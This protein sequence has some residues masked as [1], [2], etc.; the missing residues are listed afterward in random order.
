MEYQETHGVATNA[1][2]LFSFVVG[3]GSPT[4]GQFDQITWG[5]KPH[6]LQIEI[7]EGNG[8]VVMGKVK[9]QSVPYALFAAKTGSVDDADADPKNE[10]QTLSLSGRTISLSDGG[11]VTLPADADDD[12]S[13]EIQTL[14][15]SGGT[16]S[17]SKG[18]S[19][20]LPTSNDDDPSNEIQTL[21]I[22]NDTIS[23]TN[24]GKVKLPTQTLTAGTGIDIT[25]GVVSATNTS[26]LWNASQLQGVSMSS[27]KPN[28][29]DVLTY[30]GTN[31]VPGTASGGSS[32][33]KKD[34]ND[35]Y[36]DNYNVGIGTSS[37]I[38]RLHITDSIYG[39]G[40]GT[41]MTQNY[42]NGGTDGGYINY[43]F[44][45]VVAGHG[46]GDNTAGAF[47]STDDV[48][49][50][51]IARGI[52]A[53]ADGDGRYNYALHG[54]S[55]ADATIQNYGVVGVSNGTGTFNMGV[56]AQANRSNTNTNYGIYAAADSATTDYAGYFSG[57][58]TYTGTLAS[59][60]DVK[61]KRDIQDFRGAIDVIKTLEPKTY[62][63]KSEG[64]AAK[65]NL[66][67]RKQYGFLA[68]D[69][70]RN[71]P[72][73]VHT[74]KQPVSL[75]SAEVLE[76]KGVDYMSLIPVLTQAIKEQQAM[77]EELQAK[78]KAL[79]KEQNNE[80]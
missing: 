39:S 27:Q 12:P 53:I 80:K 3:E 40:N 13:N 42:L 11:S 47:Y 30:N 43:A 4:N 37:P 6:H 52:F 25:S 26:A 8:Y 22:S 14:T 60:S 74:Q 79:E 23:L 36:F 5:D 29:D 28:K 31:W 7:D 48:A 64:D 2:G 57:D 15:L 34:G 16:L 1:N 70:E 78:V 71:F 41:I 38:F 19:V 59:A 55:G 51:G 63:F 72:D 65:M 76:Y 50:T 10:I 49:S 24:G 54:I 35:I 45:S 67:D 69:L 58:V 17:L 75:E 18:G 68:Q 21:S 62:Y 46:G 77:I 9:L 73:L 32:L 66:S 44:R 61:L 33:W 20:T 56:Y